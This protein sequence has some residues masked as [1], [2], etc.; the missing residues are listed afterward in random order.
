MYVF[1]KIEKKESRQ[2][3]IKLTYK[4]ITPEM[5]LYIE[6]D[7]K[8]HF[9]TLRQQDKNNDIN[10]DSKDKINNNK[11]IV[12]VSAHCSRCQLRCSGGQNFPCILGSCYRSILPKI[13]V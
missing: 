2:T 13:R 9:F 4:T 5:I 10:I 1:V 7:S 12:A 8:K 11:K 6:F 3:N